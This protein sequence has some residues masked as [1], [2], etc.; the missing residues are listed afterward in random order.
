MDIKEFICKIFGH[1]IALVMESRYHNS[2]G[3]YT[4]KKKYEYNLV[5]GT[6]VECE[7]CGKKLSD[8]KRIKRKYYA[9][10]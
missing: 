4:T 8:F 3:S 1:K 2:R 6:Y 5:L 10:H 7:R 9:K